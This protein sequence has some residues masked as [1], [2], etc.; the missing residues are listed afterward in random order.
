MLWCH[1]TRAAPWY[2]CDKG[3]CVIMAKIAYL[4]TNKQNKFQ[5]GEE[6]IKVVTKGFFNA[7]KLKPICN[8]FI[9]ILPSEFEVYF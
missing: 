6:N 2:I 1:C 3:L 7:V 5:K 9:Q 4:V 8:N